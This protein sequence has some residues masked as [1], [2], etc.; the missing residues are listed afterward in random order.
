[1]PYLR[2]MAPSEA[3]IA[4]RKHLY[5]LNSMKSHGYSPYLRLVGLKHLAKEMENP[6]TTTKPSLKVTEYKLEDLGKR[7]NLQAQIKYVLEERR[8][9]EAQGL[10]R[11]TRSYYF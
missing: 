8:K 11:R 7:E 1:M 4:S 3:A 5:F 6:S 10:I 9:R 2:T